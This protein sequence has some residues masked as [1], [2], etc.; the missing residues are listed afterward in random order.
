MG[1]PTCDFMNATDDSP[2]RPIE[3]NIRKRQL[4]R[5]KNET[6]RHIR[7]GSSG[8]IQFKKFYESFKLKNTVRNLRKVSYFSF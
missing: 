5:D 1:L 7:K 6:P 2:L 4:S 8:K 3:R